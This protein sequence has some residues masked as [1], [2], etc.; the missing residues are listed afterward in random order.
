MLDTLNNLIYMEHIEGETVR[1]WLTM[2]GNDSQVRVVGS[3]IGKDLAHLHDL[4]VIHGDLTTSNMMMREGPNAICWIDFGLS[5]NSTLAEDK[6]VDLY[7]LERAILSTHP[8]QAESL[9][10]CIVAAYQQHSVN[11]DA[12][13]KRFE[14]GFKPFKFEPHCFTKSI[15]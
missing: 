9:F 7:V 12:V 15:P 10:Q 4:D 8:L 3:S 14:E 2:T 11:S 1:D 5:Y 13:L 6:G